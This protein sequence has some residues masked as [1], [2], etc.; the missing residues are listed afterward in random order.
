MAIR[1]GLPAKNAATDA[2][3]TRYDFSNLVVCDANGVPR[4]GV[5]APYA[6]TV[7]DA[8]ASM[9]VSVRAFNAV[10]AR[11]GGAV[12]LSNDGPVNVL[13]DAAP[14]ANSRI[15]LV[16]A[17]QNDSS[18]TVTSPDANDTPLIGV[19]KGTAAASPVKPALPVGAVDLGSVQVPA[20][21]TATNQDGVVINPP[22]Q[23]TAAP[24]G[25]VPFRTVALMN[26]WTTAQPNQMANVFADTTVTN[27]LYM[28]VYGTGWVR[29]GMFAMAQ[30]T[31]TIGTVVSGASINSTITFP[32]GRFTH[33]PFVYAM[34]A[35][36][37]VTASMSAVTTTGATLNFGNWSPATMAATGF[38]WLAIQMTPGTSD[39]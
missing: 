11:D 39:G 25:T 2:N 38:W 37:R 1:K 13:L 35:S 12:L 18:S 33:P 34:P 29:Q 28:Y 4:G 9:N 31:G 5:T 19:V 32:T 23:F 14:A 21:V 7:M 17:K 8:T 6:F 30:G 15:D 26:G 10:A 27:A 3:D 22:A 20:G 24:G 16:Y 36:S